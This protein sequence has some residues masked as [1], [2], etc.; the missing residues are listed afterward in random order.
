MKSKCAQVLC[1]DQNRHLKV[2]LNRKMLGKIENL[3]LTC[4]LLFFFFFDGIYS[5]SFPAKHTPSQAL[6]LNAISLQSPAGGLLHFFTFKEDHVSLFLVKMFL[7]LVHTIL[8]KGPPVFF[9]FHSFFFNCMW[10][11]TYKGPSQK[12][13][14]AGKNSHL[15]SNGY[16]I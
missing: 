4:G 15:F 1:F 3:N 5:L 9:F 13:C 12:F 16:Y 2:G 14:G 7:K 10:P 11:Y 6:S 8:N